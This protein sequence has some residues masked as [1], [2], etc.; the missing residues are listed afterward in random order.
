M[1]RVPVAK[2]PNLKDCSRGVG[3][4]PFVGFS[5]HSNLLAGHG[6]TLWG[7]GVQR[8]ARLGHPRIDMPRNTGS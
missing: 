7:R 1:A 4:L 8:A 5:A 2:A 3:G 6:V